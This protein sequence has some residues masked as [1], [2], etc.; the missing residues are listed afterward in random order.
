VS[1]GYRN[2]QPAIRRAPG[3]LWASVDS[4]L[5]SAPNSADNTDA[6]LVD[7]EI[8]E[9]NSIK[10]DPFLGMESGS[11]I[12]TGY[13]VKVLLIPGPH[14]RDGGAVQIILLGATDY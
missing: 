5:V 14:E 9:S 8:V 10:G 11:L 1:P 12:V 6:G 3:C 13:L 7:V 2:T 4:P